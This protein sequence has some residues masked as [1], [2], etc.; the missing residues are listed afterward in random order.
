MRE[1]VQLPRKTTSMAC[2]ARAAPGQTWAYAPI[3]HS[4]S[5]I[6]PL[7]ISAPVQKPLPKLTSMTTELIWSSQPAEIEQPAALVIGSVIHGY[8]DVLGRIE[9]EDKSSFSGELHS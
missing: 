7:L 9:E 2:P 1:L 6:A 5:M 8:R 3:T 4:C